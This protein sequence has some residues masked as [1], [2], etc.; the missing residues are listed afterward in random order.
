MGMLYL[1]RYLECWPFKNRVGPDHVGPPAEAEEDEE[2]ESAGKACGKSP[3]CLIA[4]VSRGMGIRNLR[5]EVEG[6][7]RVLV[8]RNCRVARTCRS[9][10]S[11]SLSGA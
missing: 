11:M 6:S 8:R 2:E 4:L 5:V 7:M 3:I 9:A 1:L 10:I